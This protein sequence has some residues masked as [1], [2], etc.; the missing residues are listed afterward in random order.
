VR[1][2]W[3][4]AALRW[5][6]WSWRRLGVTV[7]AFVVVTTAASA[8]QGALSRPATSR[9]V[10]EQGAAIVGGAGAGATVAA[11]RTTMTPAPSS[12]A[13]PA[14]VAPTATPSPSSSTLPTVSTTQ[15]TPVQPTPV[16]AAAARR[17]V[18]AWA[19]PALT[20]RA[21]YAA[22][23]PL[24]TPRLA[25]LLKKTDPGRVPATKVLEPAQALTPRATAAPSAT[26]KPSAST[27]A[28]ASGVAQVVVRTDAGP[29][30]VTMRSARG[31]WLVDAITPDDQPPSAPSPSG[32]T[33]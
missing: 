9:T 15:P 24:S 8:A 21:W 25:A 1:E 30:R 29:V 11:T 18:V 5:P 22:L 2:P 31:R 10:A 27:P 23:A 19:R 17:F 26:A 12:A 14:S 28:S 6:L 4:L 3:W 7:A 32:A 20:V 13:V 16:Q 33:P